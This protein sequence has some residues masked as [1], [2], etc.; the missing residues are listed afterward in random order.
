MS[1]PAPLLD[2]AAADEA[3][4]RALADESRR[5]LLDRL[6]QRDGQRLDQ[7]CAHLPQ[8][9]R[10]GVMKHLKVLE[11]AGLVASR[12]AGR[13]K[14]HYLNPVPIRLIHDRWI[15]KYAA[16]W[17]ASMADLKR[18]LEQE[19]PD[20]PRHV[21]EVYIRT[22]PERLWQALIAREDTTR[23][24]YGG[25]FESSWRVGEAYRTLLQDGTVPFQ[26]TVLEFDPPR[27]LVYS[28]QHFAHEGGGVDE[29]ASRVSWE[30][31]P[32]GPM[33]KLTVVHDGFDAETPTFKSVGSGWPYIL[34]SLKSYLETG[35]PLPTR[36]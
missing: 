17:A 7:L 3:V 9:T 20:A 8:M 34:S 23:Y 1:R 36:G 18:E 19:M 16:P 35:D 33:C 5:L 12:R 15:S 22:T 25:R 4:F 10:F 14:L 13:E 11:A 27:R 26:G 32:V 31:E 24:L 30:I 2:M 6:F 29:Q 28:F 21:Y